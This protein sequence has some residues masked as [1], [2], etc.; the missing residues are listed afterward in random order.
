VSRRAAAALALAAAGTGA[1][2][3]DLPPACDLMRAADLSQV[4][5]AGLSLDALS[6]QRVEDVRV[7]I[8]SASDEAA[9]TSLSVLLRTEDGETRPAGELRATYVEELSEAMDAPV[10]AT[11]RDIGEAAVWIEDVGQL[12]VWWQDGQA[13]MIVTGFGG[14]RQAQAE[15]LAAAILDV[16]P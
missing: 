3:A 4:T 6:D 15:A 1:A 9:G 11:E 13:M 2:A 10:D 8:C 16:A 5:D 12:T 14:A 7:S